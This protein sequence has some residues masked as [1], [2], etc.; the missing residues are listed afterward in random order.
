M[1]VKQNYSRAARTPLCDEAR[2]QAVSERVRGVRQAANRLDSRHV[3][4]RWSCQFQAVIDAHTERQCRA[5]SI[6]KTKQKILNDSSTWGAPEV[7]EFEK[8]STVTQS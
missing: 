6:E 2:C 5:D 7:T 8:P 3:T 4:A 1:D